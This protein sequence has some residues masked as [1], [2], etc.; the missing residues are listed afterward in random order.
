MVRLNFSISCLADLSSLGNVKDVATSVV[1]S[2]S[3]VLDAGEIISYDPEFLKKREKEILK[4]VAASGYRMQHFFHL[5]SHYLE[6]L[7]EVRVQREAAE[8]DNFLQE[9]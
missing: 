8:M 3:K 7:N 9:D 6:R 2:V 4:E 5:R 1:D